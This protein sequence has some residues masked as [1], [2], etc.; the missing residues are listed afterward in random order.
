MVEVAANGG[1]VMIEGRPPPCG[2]DHVLYGEAL[3]VRTEF[4]P[5]S[6]STPND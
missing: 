5:V 6:Q 1:A 4:T 3:V 2:G